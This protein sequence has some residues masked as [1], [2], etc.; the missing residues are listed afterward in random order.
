MAKDS[1]F[2]IVSVVNMQEVD[3]AVNQTNKEI[4]QRFDFKNSKS[5]VTLEGEDIK[6]LADDDYKLKSVIDILQSKLIRRKVSIKNLEYGKVEEAS[7][8]MVRQVIKVKQGIDTE[9]A[10]K[11][12]KDIK[13]SKLKVQAQIM[14][15][16]VRV[17]GKSRDEL[18][19]VITLLREQDYNIDLQFTNYR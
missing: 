8:G 6:I 19:A 13:N 17:S 12:V 4:S 3:N 10:K 2:D 5:Q 7:G 11:I 9:L 1:S 18:Q 16:Q 14:N 15:D